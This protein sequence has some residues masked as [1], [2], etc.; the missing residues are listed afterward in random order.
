MR[1]PRRAAAG[2]HLG[3]PVG[4]RDNQAV[5]TTSGRRHTCERVAVKSR[6]RLKTGEGIT[7]RTS[8]PCYLD[9]ADKHTYRRVVFV[10][11][12]SDEDQSSRARLDEAFP[13]AKRVAET[14]LSAAST[15]N[16]GTA[17]DAKAAKKAQLLQMCRER[18]IKNLSG[19]S[20]SQLLALLSPDG[21]TAVLRA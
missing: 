15:T 3:R 9:V 10:R 19:K 7:F 8:C 13:E 1:G 16:T 2:A 5:R 6:E 20:K 14:M 11:I 12:R 17:V 4:E 21:G 18:G